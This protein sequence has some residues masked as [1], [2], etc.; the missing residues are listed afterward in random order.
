MM[1]LRVTLKGI[2][3]AYFRLINSVMKSE[4]NFGKLSIKY[5]IGLRLFVLFTSGTHN[6]WR[7]AHSVYYR[8]QGKQKINKFI[9]DRKYLAL[10][11]SISN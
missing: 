6:I 8:V 11:Q 1:V 9:P 5:K 10:D 3:T 7:I 2:L 4:S